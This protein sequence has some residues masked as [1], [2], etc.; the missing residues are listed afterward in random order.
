M[1]EYVKIP[2][3]FRRETFGKNKLIDGQYSLPEEG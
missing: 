1:I 2:N 3:V